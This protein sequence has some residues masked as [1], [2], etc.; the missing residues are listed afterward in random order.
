MRP[1]GHS[2]TGRLM[3]LACTSITARAVAASTTAARVL[4]SSARQAVPLR[5]SRVSQPADASQ[6]SSLSGGTPCFLKS[7]KLQARPCAASQARAFLTVSQL[8]MP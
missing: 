6:A 3:T 1:S 5:L 4:S 8:G 7:W 2:T